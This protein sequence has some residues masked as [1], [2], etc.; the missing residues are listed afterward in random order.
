M[1]S[2]NDLFYQSGGADLSGDIAVSNGIY[3]GNDNAFPASTTYDTYG[4]IQKTAGGGA[5][6]FDQAGSIVYRARLSA[7]SGR[8]SH[9][10]YTGAA[11][12]L[13]FRIDETQASFFAGN[14]TVGGNTTGDANLGTISSVSLNKYY[15]GSFSMTF[16]GPWASNQT[17]TVNYQKIGRQVTLSIVGSLGATSNSGA[18]G[19]IASTANLPSGLYPP[20]GG[21][22]SIPVVLADNSADT[23][24]FVRIRNAASLQF[25]K[26]PSTNFTNGNFAGVEGFSVTYFSAT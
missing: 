19:V 7:V 13:A 15:V 20:A 10:F 25:F 24:G 17:I 2:N 6:P 1:P 21:D 11:P 14:V 3:I 8:S 12:A 4:S 16:T 5:S 26:L 18:V 22:V 9:Y 23:T